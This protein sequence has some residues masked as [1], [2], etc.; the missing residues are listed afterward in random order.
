MTLSPRPGASPG[1]LFALVFLYVSF[2]TVFGL[3]AALYGISRFAGLIVLMI[4][5]QTIPLIGWAIFYATSDVLLIVVL[6]SIGEMFSRKGADAT[7][8]TGKDQ[9]VQS[10]YVAS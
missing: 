7:G 5:T 1:F 8:A 6:I 9:Q 10:Q 3:Y 2:G 4:A